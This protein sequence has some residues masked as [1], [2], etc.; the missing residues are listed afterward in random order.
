LSNSIWKHQSSSLETDSIVTS[1]RA[2]G[3]ALHVEFLLNGQHFIPKMDPAPNGVL[4][5]GHVNALKE[6][7]RSVSRATDLKIR[8]YSNVPVEKADVFATIQPSWAN[9]QV[10]KNSAQPQS[11]SYG[12]RFLMSIV[13]SSIKGKWRNRTYIHGHSGYIIYALVTFV[14]ARLCRTFAYHSIYCPVESSAIIDGKKKVLASNRLAR[15]ALL[16]MDRIVAMSD[17]IATSLVGLGIPDEKIVVCPPGIDTGKFRPE[18]ERGQAFRKAQG[19]SGDKQVIMYVGNLIASKG[20][21]SL[22]DAFLLLLENH[23]SVHLLITLEIAHEGF[24][25]RFKDLKVFLSSHEISDKVTILGI[26]DNIECAYNAADVYVLP[27]L[28]NNGP[29]D[30]PIAAMEAMSSGVPVV[31]TTVGAIPELVIAGRTGYLTEPGNV[32]HLSEKLSDLLSD[33]HARKEMGV[34]ARN[35]ILHKY[36]LDQVYNTMLDVYSKDIERARDND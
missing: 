1:N 17:N 3:D 23:E 5:G 30:Y 8:L 15:I 7:A 33:P 16:K 36:S 22:M 31:G 18:A 12:L 6:F 35:R 13:L 11:Y 32:I 20:L 9:F 10:Q 19:I 26:I 29:S 14:V 34:E 21:Q 4:V 2:G 28:D 25:N 27:Y 24:E